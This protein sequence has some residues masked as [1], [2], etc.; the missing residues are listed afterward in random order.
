MK[1]FFMLALGLLACGCSS[2]IR[3]YAPSHIGISPSMEW[4]VQEGNKVK[5]KPRV[6]SSIDW[7][8]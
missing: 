2:H 5:Y 6:G 3:D 1:Y 8:F 7:N 4:E